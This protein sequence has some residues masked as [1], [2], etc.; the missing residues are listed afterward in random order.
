M[1]VTQDA[2]TRTRRRPK[3][4]PALG[5]ALLGVILTAGLALAVATLNGGFEYGDFTGWT[6]DTPDPASA[7]DVVQI[8]LQTG[9]NLIYTAAEGAYFALLQSGAS[10]VPTIVARRFELAA[11][12]SVGCS[13]FFDTLALGDGNS[14]GKVEMFDALDNVI[15]TPFSHDGNT[16][17]G[18]T[19][20]QS[21]TFEAP[22]SGTYTVK[23]S[24]VGAN[25]YYPSYLGLDGCGDAAPLTLANFAAAAQTGG[26][27]QVAWETSGGANPEAFNVYRAAAAD[28]PYVKV[29]PDTIEAAGPSM[30]NARYTLDDRP[31]YGAFWYR[32][33]AVSGGGATTVWGP[34]SVT[35]RSG[36]RLPKHR[37]S[38]PGQ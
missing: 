18:Y 15:A 3:L 4:V 5:L 10:G 1:S 21:W 38:P 14:L 31:G 26:R 12:E 29:T 8:H 2:Y 30:A 16:D 23:A 17:N 36:F 27:V 24:V 35:A 20:W 25:P 19:D 33:E 34:V 32:L 7:V 11:H 37:P 22:Q 13:A 6:V 28:G 9:D